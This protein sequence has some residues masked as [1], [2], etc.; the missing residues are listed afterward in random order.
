MASSIVQRQLRRKVHEREPRARFR[1]GAGGDEAGPRRRDPEQLIDRIRWRAQ[2]SLPWRG[3]FSLGGNRLSCPMNELN[4]TVLPPGHKTKLVC[5]IGPASDNP[6]TLERLLR[7][8]MNVARLEF[9]PRRLPGP[10]TDHRATARSGGCYRAA[11]GHHGRS[12]GT[13]DPDRRVLRQSPSNWSA[14]SE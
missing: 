4:K 11:P 13:E 5:T 9:F 10:R 12:A 1:T 6:H 8:G 7:A 3:G 2:E 14:G